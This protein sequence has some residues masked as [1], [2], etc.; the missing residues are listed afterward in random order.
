VN[1]RQ[2]R[3]EAAWPM[4]TSAVHTGPPPAGSTAFSIEPLGAPRPQ[5][6]SGN[7]LRFNGK[8]AYFL[9]YP[10]EGHHLNGLANRRDLTTRYFEFFDHFLKGAPAPKWM[11][12]GVPYLVK[13]AER[14]S[15]SR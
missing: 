8:E 10:G 4:I 15:P 9:A 11:T 14:R 2:C 7:A 5:V 1:A 13:E 6:R 12:D 3:Q